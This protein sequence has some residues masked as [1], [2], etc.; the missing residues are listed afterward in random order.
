[1][2]VV[3]NI[4]NCTPFRSP[5]IIDRLCIYINPLATSLSYQKCY[6]YQVQPAAGTTYKLEPIHIPISLGEFLN[7][8]TNH[9]L[10]NHRKMAV[11]HYHSQQRQH[12]R[13]TKGL[14]GHNLLAKPLQQ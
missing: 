1:M 10:R 5:C 3:I 14:P 12:V 13:M 8:P 9:P 4:Q 7:I 6:E 2:G 11:A